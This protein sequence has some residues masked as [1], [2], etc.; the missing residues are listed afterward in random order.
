M[1]GLGMI[2][3]VLLSAIGA[4]SAWAD[5][6]AEVLSANASYERAFSSLDINAIDAAWAHDQNV[7]VVHPS[8]KAVIVGWE[9]VRKSY[10][11]QPARHKEF[12]V[13]MDNPHI[14]V[15]GGT[16][17][18]V[19]MEKIHTILTN[20]QVADLSAMATSVYEKRNGKW[21]LVHHHGSRTPE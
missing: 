18:I 2:L 5:D 3:A 15:A 20:G 8:S 12:S 4:A 13:V 9:A 10:A 16:A 11:D 21:L 19:G 17:W 1:R 7:T 6:V 14:I